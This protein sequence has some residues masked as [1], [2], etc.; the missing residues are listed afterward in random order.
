VFVSAVT[1]TGYKTNAIVSITNEAKPSAISKEYSVSSTV[2]K[3]YHSGNLNLSTIPFVAS[4]VTANTF[5]S[6]VATGT[7]P[8]TVSSTTLVNNLN[9]S[10]FNGKS[11]SD[12]IV[13]GPNY[14]DINF[15]LTATR[16]NWG[17]TNTGLPYNWAFVNYIT[18]GVNTDLYKGQIAIKYDTSEL[19]FR[20]INQGVANAWRKV[21]HDGNFISGIDYA[22]AFSTLAVNKGGTGL[23]SLGTAQQILRVNS[24]GTALEYATASTIP[25][26]AELGSVFIAGLYGFSPT[27]ST[28][29]VN[30]SGTLIADGLMGAS[31]Y[32]KNPSGITNWTL[33]LGSSGELEFKNASGVKKF[34]IDQS[35]NLVTAGTITAT[36]FILG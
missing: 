28:V 18:F 13:Y 35:G 16:S 23:S 9:T 10:Y 7:A 14:Q 20:S 6:S 8:F 27:W 24:A 12:F 25:Y 5:A 4:T 21:W 1:A 30:T 22:P 36:N 26:T 17:W 34:S 3:S 32:V 2:K 11:E 15:A 29:K 33:T 19:A 31:V